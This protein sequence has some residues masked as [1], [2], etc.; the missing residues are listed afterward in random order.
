M[1][2][3]REELVNINFYNE[4]IDRLRI[5][6]L[7][8]L[9]NSARNNFRD[10]NGILYSY[11]DIETRLGIESAQLTTPYYSTLE[12]SLNRTEL[13]AFKEQLGDPDDDG[14]VDDFQSW[15]SEHSKV[16]YLVNS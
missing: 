3:T 4:F 13:D 15:I 2:Y 11:E 16:S 10:E 14:Y 12:T 7:N 8:K 5:E 6:Y 1:P 9:V